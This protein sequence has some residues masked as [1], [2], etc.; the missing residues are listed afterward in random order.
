MADAHR[1]EGREIGSQ[2][3]ITYVT[4]SLKI[5]Y[6]QATLLDNEVI[7][8]RAKV[9]RVEG[10]KTF[11][12]CSLFAQNIKTVQGEVLGIKINEIP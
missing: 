4:A 5:D 9:D 3:L 6:L 2:P 11:I 8:L 7:E 1:R 10:K 12:S